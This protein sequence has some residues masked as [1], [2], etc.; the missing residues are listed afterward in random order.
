MEI[1]E[2]VENKKNPQIQQLQQ[3]QQAATLH[4]TQSQPNIS[5]G[6][7]EE[8]DNDSRASRKK[9]ISRK[10]TKD[11][12]VSFATSSQLTQYLEPLD[13]F[14]SFGMYFFLHYAFRVC[15]AHCIYIRL[16]VCALKKLDSVVIFHCL[17]LSLHLSRSRSYSH[18][19]CSRTF[20]SLSI[21]M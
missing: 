11:R 2:N 14:Q 20:K 19:E 13:P 10:G 21:V 17:K 12:R 3:Q 5:S 4:T 15:I 6:G 9:D 16:C 18:R 8:D 1:G 7:G